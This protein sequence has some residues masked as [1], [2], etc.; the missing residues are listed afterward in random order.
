MP[1]LD[2]HKV[3]PPGVYAPGGL[4][5]CPEC[6]APL[7]L[8]EDVDHGGGECPHC[9]TAIDEDEVRDQLTAQAEPREW[10]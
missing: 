10:G 1:F 6:S 3:N 2:D 9:H 4:I 7:E 5:D 8:G